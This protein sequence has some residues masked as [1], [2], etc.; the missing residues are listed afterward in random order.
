MKRT[1]SCFLFGSLCLVAAPEV[2]ADDGDGLMLPRLQGRV[3]LGMSAAPPDM[4][5]IAGDRLSGA[6]FLGDYYF[7]RQASREGD[8]SGFRA[9]SGVFVGSR[10][11][12]WGGA[13][14]PALASAAPF[15]LEHTSF[16][17]L[18]PASD[19]S[20]TESPTVPYLGLGYS[21]GSLR[22]GWAFSADLGLMALN[23]GNAIRLGR[24][25]G[26]AQ[27]LEDVLRDL[28]FAPVAQIGVFYSF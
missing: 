21:S 22:G 2:R 26:S 15:A 14:T 10:P 11:A 28:R 12:L 13:A 16:S 8:A 6:S 1:L 23:P 7:T 5:A 4:A 3:R 20:G 9:T 27:N 17:L 19:S 25:L 18:P 24:S